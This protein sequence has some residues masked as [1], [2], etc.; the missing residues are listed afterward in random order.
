MLRVPARR[1]AGRAQ[2]RRG[3][4]A[5]WVSVAVARRRGLGAI[6]KPEIDFDGLLKGANAESVDAL[7]A[8]I[9]A[10]A[11]A[12]SLPEREQ[13]ILMLFC[14]GYTLEQIGVQVGLSKGR[15]SQILSAIKQRGG[16]VAIDSDDYYA[17]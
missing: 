9:D 2:A 3:D 16:K 1:Q 5:R 13:K 15:I 7:D 8:L 12:K 4:R 14:E 10:V 17:E 11:Y 6:T